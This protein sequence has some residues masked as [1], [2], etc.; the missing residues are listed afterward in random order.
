LEHS[1]HSPK[2][3]L[4]ERRKWRVVSEENNDYFDHPMV[5]PKTILRRDYQVK[6][7]TRALGSPTLVVL[8]TGLGKTVV[9]LMVIA[10]RIAQGE[11][12][13]LMMAPTKPL[14]EQHRS[15]LSNYLKVEGI[16]MLTGEVPPA[17]RK[18]AY[19]QFQVM[20]STPQVIKL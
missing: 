14:V 9:A 18:E 10:E 17:K 7:A 1:V 11:G 16:G 5:T 8:P 4:Y 15:F 20:V 6:I 13:V 2:S 12:P 19:S 3:Y